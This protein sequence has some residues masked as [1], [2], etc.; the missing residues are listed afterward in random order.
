MSTENPPQIDWRVIHDPL[1]LSFSVIILQTTPDGCQYT[2]AD[3]NWDI[4]H[5]G[6]ECRIAFTVPEEIAHR[7]PPELLPALRAAAAAG[8]LTARGIQGNVEG[9]LDILLSA[10]ERLIDKVNNGDGGQP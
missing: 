6:S 5:P 10:T 9:A 1:R 2:W 7:G 3:G 8:D 4:H